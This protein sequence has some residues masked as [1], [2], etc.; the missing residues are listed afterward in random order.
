MASW[1]GGASNLT[2]SID[3]IKNQ[4]REWGLFYIC[5]LTRSPSFQ[6][7]SSLRE[8]FEEEE[9]SDPAAQLAVAKSKVGSTVSS[10]D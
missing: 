7:S 2:A 4:V 1:F 9:P 10:P 6:V 3:S 5:S 8:V